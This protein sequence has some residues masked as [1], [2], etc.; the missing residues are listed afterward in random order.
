MN[1]NSNVMKYTIQNLCDTL[2]TI[3]IFHWIC[4]RP[5][6]SGLRNVRLL[7]AVCYL[8]PPVNLKPSE[9]ET[10]DQRGHSLICS[11]KNWPKSVLFF[12]FILILDLLEIGAII[13]THFEIQCLPYARFFFFFIR[14]HFK[15]TITVQLQSCILSWE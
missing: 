9:M 11:T 12:P 8:S 5:F 6:Q 1:H 4:P 2:I 13:Q 3:I 10:S 7:T 14:K 15:N